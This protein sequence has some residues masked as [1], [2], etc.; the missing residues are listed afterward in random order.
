MKPSLSVMLTAALFTVLFSPAP[1]RSQ[2]GAVTPLGRAI[3]GMR[4]REIGPALMGGRVSDIAVDEANP[5]TFYVGFASGGLWKTTSQ[6]M[7]W[8]PLFDDQGTASIGAVSLAPSNPNIVWVGTG[9]PQNRQSSPWGEGMYRSLDGG[10]TWLHRGLRDTRHIGGISIHPRDPDVVYVAAAGHLFGPNG[11]RGV[12]RT[13]DGGETWQKVLYIDEHTGAIDLA[14][15]PG[16]PNTLFAAMYQR[17]RT[18]W[19]FSGSGGGSGLYRTL[20]GGN[21]WQELTEGL[22]EGDK[23]RIGVDVYRRDG[24]LVYARI[25]SSGEG[26]GVYRSRDR[27]ETWEKMSG[28][29][30][31]PMY[32][33]MIRI[34]PNDPERIYLGG[35]SLPVSDD[36]GRTWWPRDGAQN[37]HVDHHALWIDPNDSGH[38]IL[39]SDGGIS[40]SFDRAQTWRHHNNLAVGQFY[41]IGVDMRDPYYV[42]GGLQDNSSWCG[43]SETLNSYGIRNGDW[44]DVSGGDGFYNRIDPTDPNIMYTESQGGNMSRYHVDTG[45]S[46]RIRPVSRAAAADSTLNY[47]WNWSTPIHISHH[48]PATL[49]V[50]ANHVLRSRDRGM[51]WEEASPDITRRVDRDTL[52]IM[53]QRVTG[54]TLSR[55][56]G[57][58]QYGTITVLGE[59]PLSAEVIY[60]GTDD[61]IVQV[62]RDGG[63]SWTDVS[64]RVPGLRH[65]M[66]VSSLDPSRHVEGRVYL[67]FDGHYSDHYAPHVLVSEDYGGSWRPITNGLPDWSVNVVREHPRTPDLLFAGNEVGAYVSIDRGASWQRLRGGFPTVP[68]DDIVIHPRENDLV[69]GTHGRSIWILDDVTPLE[70]LARPQVLASAAHL[71]PVAPATMRSRAGGWPFWGDLYAAPNPADGALI[72]YHLAADAPVSASAADDERNAGES[73]GVAQ[74]SV[75]A[76]DRSANRDRSRGS[77]ADS[78]TLT[79]ADAAGN[80]VRTLRGAAKAGLHEITWDLRMEPPYTPDRSGQGQGGGGFGGPPRGPRVLPGNYA[81][82]L[83]A[84]GSSAEATF[85]V[86]PDPRVRIAASDLAGR[87]RALLDLHELA[88][89]LYEAGLAAQQA[90]S[91]LRAIRTTL[92]AATSPPAALLAETDTV[93]TRLRDVRRQ[94]GRAGQ[95]NRLPGAIEGASVI[96]TA[97]QQWQLEQ[98]WIDVPAAIRALNELLSGPLAALSAR[99]YTEEARPAPIDAVRLPER[100][101]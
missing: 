19:G 98:A 14:M 25:E 18:P 83:D 88:A 92:E 79:I 46:V 53:G 30:P 84:A 20:D 61:G 43:P 50:G 29:N 28:Q 32:F 91:R 65:G 6:G 16:D 44:Y 75:D 40:S 5:S 68:V 64:S 45:E 10:R 58:S 17:Q 38:L 89:P 78:V 96:P 93:E 86:R 52:T 37:I 1:V 81:V 7:S 35:V 90:E 8:S 69:L 48:D 33:G 4:F 51:T 27:G 24:N 99:V 100:A 12:F 71:F 56:D 74:R 13:R 36:G 15:D 101:R 63:E 49:Y 82:R 67:A 54:E 2:N 11:E 87:Q 77:A 60:A 97:D 31:R 70:H 42:C 3:E 41:A 9:E 76:Q 55:N 59:S 66:V 23:G 94:L 26:R 80:S 22:P 73:S 21:T 39:G 34:D 95:A 85:E 62:T 72:R 57:V 47:R